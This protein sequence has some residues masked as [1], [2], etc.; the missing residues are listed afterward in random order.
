M[1]KTVSVRVKRQFA[2]P[3]YVKQRTTSKKFLAHDEAGVCKVRERGGGGGRE[4]G[5]TVS[6]VDHIRTARRR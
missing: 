4:G 1:D 5:A 6:F 2:D 3:L